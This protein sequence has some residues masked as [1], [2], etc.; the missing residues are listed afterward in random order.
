MDFIEIKNL[1]FRYAGSSRKA[2]DGVSLTIA[3]GGF[4]LLC[5]PSGGG[6]TTLLHHLKSGL[7]PVGLRE[8]RILYRGRPL[9][10]V[11]PAEA[12]ADFGLVF[13]HPE[14]QVVMDTVWHEMAFSME[15]LGLPLS[16]MHKRLAELAHFFGL[17]PLLHRSVHELSGGQLQLV[18]LA[19]VLLL[20][21]KVLLLDEPTSQLDPVSAREFLFMLQR[22]NRELGLTVIMSEHR[23]E[24]ALP[25]ADAVFLLDGG[26]LA[27]GGAPH[28]FARQAA[29]AGRA[30][31]LPAAARLS[32]SAGAPGQPGRGTGPAAVPDPAAGR[33]PAQAATEPVGAEEAA[34]PVKAPDPAADLP[35]LTVR[36]GRRWLEQAGERLLI[37]RSD[38]LRPELPPSQDDPLLSCREISFR[39]G[40]DDPAVL[41]R[42][43]LN[44][45]EREFLA[46]FGGN[47]AG[48]STLLQVLAGLLVPKRGKV[49]PARGV[50]IGYLAQNPLLYFSYDTLGEEFE[51]AVRRSGAGDARETRSE[52]VALLGLEELLDRHPHDLSGGERQKAALGLVLMARPDLLCIDE[53]TKGLDPE[54]KR[55]VGLLLQDLRSRGLTLI[56]VTHDVEFAAEYASRCAL[57]FDGAIAAEDAPAA[58]FASNYFYTTALNRL[59][60]DRLP[61]ALTDEDVICE[62][63]VPESPSSS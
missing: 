47:G 35:P 13:Q 22:L 18:N 1:T 52:L 7:Q 19:S 28:A 8:G 41:N 42:L 23:L 27:A 63:A 31:Y 45:R 56:M 15:N 40:K 51:Q 12:A 2:L 14:S 37:R 11:T 43:S 53:P 26:R 58:F 33:G 17:E 5:G 3:E 6:K 25:L 32:L 16:V 62:W 36:E 50:R 10:E 44:I 4:T 20:Q 24:D 60:R 9:D 29:A 46:V 38:R 21:P 57:L 49:S 34:E 30:L 61:E 48:K 55:R 39:Y 59:L 54:A